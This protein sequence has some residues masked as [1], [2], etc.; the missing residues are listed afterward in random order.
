MNGGLPFKVPLRE[1]PA[2]R[3]G[4]KNVEHDDWIDV[5]KTAQQNT[6]PGDI[7]ITP[8]LSSTFRWYAERPEVGTWKDMPQDAKSIVEWWQRMSD[9]HANGRNDPGKRWY[10][11]VSELE[12]TRLYEVAGKYGARYVIVQLDEDLPRLRAAPKYQ[13]KSYAIYTVE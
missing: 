12:G 5:C 11:S 3:R 7:F 9:L 4:D 10:E 1:A 2:T 13:N 8:R 6:N